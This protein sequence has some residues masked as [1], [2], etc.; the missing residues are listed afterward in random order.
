MFLFS[1]SFLY[2]SPAWWFGPSTSNARIVFTSTSAQGTGSPSYPLPSTAPASSVAE[3]ACHDQLP[4]IAPS[5]AGLSR[6]RSH[7]RCCSEWWR[8]RRA[9]DWSWRQR[10][11]GP[12]GPRGTKYWEGHGR[13]DEFGFSSIWRLLFRQSAF[14]IFSKPS[15][16]SSLIYFTVIHSS[17]PYST[18]WRAFCRSPE[19][20]DAF[21]FTS[22]RCT[23]KF[24]ASTLQRVV[25]G[26]RHGD[27]SK[28]EG[29]FNAAMVSGSATEGGQ[30]G[31]SSEWTERYWGITSRGRNSPRAL[32][33]LRYP[34]S[35]SYESRTI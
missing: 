25:G 15:P 28:R 27:S 6:S 31:R 16:S 20:L 35:E 7:R 5:Q 19:P 8:W 9:P 33:W 12:T 32:F 21:W 17:K 13:C 24:E 11:K 29:P 18:I 2:A 34:R 1:F 4:A 30:Q 26:K 3:T 22:H 14:G 23:G 10:F